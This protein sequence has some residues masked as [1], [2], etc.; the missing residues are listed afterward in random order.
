MTD[1]TNHQ[2]PHPI[3]ATLE[4][5]QSQRERAAARSR[6]T[7]AGEREIGLPPNVKH[8]KRRDDGGR[9]LKY[10]AVTYFPERF[11][12]EFSPDHLRCIAKMER[13]VVEGDL[14]A[15]AMARGSGKTT[16]C[17]VALLWALLYG[18]RS[19][20]VLVGADK[21]AAKGLLDS[22]KI[23]L[24][25]N[26]LLYDDFPEV[27]H[28]VRALDGLANRCKGQTCKGHRTHI[29]WSDH[30]I[31]MPCVPN[32]KCSGSIVV[33]RGLTAGI[34]GLKHVTAE[35]KSLRPDLCVIDDPQTEESA[36][37][38]GQCETRVNILAGA[39]LGLAGPGKKI[40]GVMPCTVI[41]PGD[42][43]D[44][45]LDRTLYPQWNGERCK[46]VYSWPERMDLWDQYC[47]IVRDDMRAEKGLARATAFYAKN[48]KAMDKGFDVAWPQRK[49][50]EELSAQQHVW[51]LIVRH[52]KKMFAAEFQNDPEDPVLVT[53]EGMDWLRTV[54]D[55][56]AK[57]SGYKRLIVPD[58]A[59]MMTAMVDVHEDVLYYAVAAWTQ[60]FTGWIV[61]YGTWPRQRKR[62]FA[63]NNAELTLTK[64]YPNCKGQTAALLHAGLNDLYRELLDSPWKTES[65]GYLTIDRLL[66][67]AQDNTDTVYE[68]IRL[69]PY[70]SRIYPSHGFA[71]GANKERIDAKKKE[72]GELVGYHWRIPSVRKA[73]RGVR[74]VRFD[75][76][77]YKT[78]LHQRMA[79]PRGVDGC[80]E[81][82]H[83]DASH[84]QLLAE[85]WTAEKPGETSG[86]YGAR[87]EWTNQPGRDNHWLDCGVGCAV[88]ASIQGATLPGA[89]MGTG[90]KAERRTIRLSERRSR[91][92]RDAA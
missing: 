37:S 35:G 48:R 43:A 32:S 92:D 63:K 34:R 24:E 49:A 91:R 28:A 71:V 2:P 13:A 79:A 61:D 55:I 10:F 22:I 65:G 21:E 38:V 41:R 72:P 12:L 11:P 78:F 56:T 87:I 16:L 36:N 77:I 14:F 75:P 90:V 73:T 89:G 23:E 69:S 85:H 51:N 76:N 83:E 25:T 9:S 1:E 66:T 26:D 8:Q 70:R 88:A 42:M 74:Y 5:D 58:A 64:Y 19:F 33:C 18:F 54:S 40:A 81:L 62:Y 60:S 6:E 82:Y 45:I 50:E 27:C 84:H 7:S 57:T 30:K 67:D 17:E 29:K 15:L 44:R 4:S 68:V 47:E 20:L 80:L 3:D 59:T 31:I 86:P 46:L 39:I 52:G 53:T